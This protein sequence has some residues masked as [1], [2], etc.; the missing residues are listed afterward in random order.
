MLIGVT[1]LHFV[2]RLD[3]VFQMCISEF[4]I[5]SVTPPKENKFFQHT[6]VF[7]NISLIFFC[8]LPGLLKTHN[9]GC[10]FHASRGLPTVFKLYYATRNNMLSTNVILLQYTNSGY[11]KSP[12]N[13]KLHYQANKTKLFHFICDFNTAY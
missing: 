9:T 1:Q 13:E 6:S 7:S 4:Q 10:F 8:Q 2:Y 3:E 5:H 11:N 12:K